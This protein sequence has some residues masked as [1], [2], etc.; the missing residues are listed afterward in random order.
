MTLGEVKKKYAA[1]MWKSETVRMRVNAEM[2]PIFAVVVR[3]RLAVSLFGS[4]CLN[5]ET[6]ITRRKTSYVICANL[7]LEP[8]QHNYNHHRCFSK[9]TFER[10]LFPHEI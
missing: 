2:R 9:A 1:V 6:E 4:L 10:S 5:V 3:C 7:F 8:V